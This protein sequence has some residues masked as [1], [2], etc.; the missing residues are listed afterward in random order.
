MKLQ[1]CFL[2]GPDGI[3]F[4]AVLLS[5][6]FTSKENM[7]GD[8]IALRETV[9]RIYCFRYMFMSNQILYMLLGQNGPCAV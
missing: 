1:N 2:P 9:L 6:E 4:A 3:S 7:H 5:S 8:K